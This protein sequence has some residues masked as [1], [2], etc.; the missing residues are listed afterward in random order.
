MPTGDLSACDW[1][2]QSCRQSLSGLT[3][4]IFYW[5]QRFETLTCCC[6]LVM[7]ASPGGSVGGRWVRS[8]PGCDPRALEG[9]EGALSLAGR[10][11]GCRRTALLVTKASGGLGPE[12]ETLFMVQD[13][14]PPRSRHLETFP[15]PPQH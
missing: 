14:R 3:S 2:G 4:F 7:L 11:R 15:D 12:G 10:G 1:P 5:F 9:R 13:W 8:C 6:L